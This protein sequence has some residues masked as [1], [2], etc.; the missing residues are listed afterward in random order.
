MFDEIKAAMS[1]II[2]MNNREM[3]A[4]LGGSLEDLT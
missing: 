4:V 2:V 3:A 1:A